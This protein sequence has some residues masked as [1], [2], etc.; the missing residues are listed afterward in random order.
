MTFYCFYLCANV[1]LTILDVLDM[2]FVT[3]ILTLMD[4]SL[5]EDSA[6]LICDRCTELLLAYN[7]QF[8]DCKPNII[9]Q[10][11]KSMPTVKEFFGKLIA[12]TNREGIVFC[13]TF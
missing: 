13:K 7:L 6:D 4:D 9:L 10:A 1:F 5:P 11:L 3:F 12:L 8:A 2:N